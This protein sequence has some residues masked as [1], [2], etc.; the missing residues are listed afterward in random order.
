[1]LVDVCDLVCSADAE[2]GIVRDKVLVEEAVCGTAAAG[3]KLDELVNKG[4]ADKNGLEIVVEITS[5]C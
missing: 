2:V 3:I 5:V 1:M 4:A